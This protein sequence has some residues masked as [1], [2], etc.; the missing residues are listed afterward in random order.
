MATI[1]D[2]FDAMTTR[3]HYKDAKD[4]F[5]ALQIMKNEMRDE[6]DQGYFA[7][8]VQMMAEAS[9]LVKK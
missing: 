2:I 4:S 8:F 1:C 6:L 9:G 7:T 3:R 5:Q